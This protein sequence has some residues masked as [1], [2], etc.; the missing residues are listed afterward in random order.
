MYRMWTADFI[1]A[2]ASIVIRLAGNE[3]S[4]FADR[5]AI[6]QAFTLEATPTGPVE[7]DVSAAA[8]VGRFVGADHGE[9]LDFKGDFLYAI[10]VRGPG[11][12][13]IGDAHFTADSDLIAGALS[14]V[15]RGAWARVTFE[16]FR[17]D[18]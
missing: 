17:T 13:N 12:V 4:R 5:N 3:D 2:H 9:G 16:S 10:D 6:I 7:I 14:G 8:S 11:G 15:C 18:T 1:A